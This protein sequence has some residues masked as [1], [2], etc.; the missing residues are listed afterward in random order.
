MSTVERQRNERRKR[1]WSELA[2]QTQRAL[3]EDDWQGASQAYFGQAALLFAEGKE[4]GHA[5]SEAHKFELMRM[6]EV[7]M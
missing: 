4:H 2:Q 5:A 7:G 6:S 1:R 3:N